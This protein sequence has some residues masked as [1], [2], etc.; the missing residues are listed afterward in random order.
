MG[1]IRTPHVQGVVCVVVFVRIYQGLF[2]GCRHR[3]RSLEGMFMRVGRHQSRP[4]NECGR[5]VFF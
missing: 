2:K 1:Q 3:P 5:D 4:A